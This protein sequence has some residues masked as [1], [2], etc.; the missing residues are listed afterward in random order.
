MC[1]RA[2]RIIEFSLGPMN[3]ECRNKGRH[4]EPWGANLSA[5]EQSVHEDRRMLMKLA[6]LIYRLT[7]WRGVRQ[8]YFEMYARC[9]R[10]KQVVADVD[11][12]TYAL[13][14]GE[15]IDL[16]IF[17]RTFEPGVV[18]ALEK[19]SRLGMVVLDIGANI[20]AHVL[21]LA[22]RVGGTG[23]VYAFEPTTFAFAK[24]ERNLQLNPTLNVVATRLALSDEP[25]TTCRISFR[26]SWRTDGKRQDQSC[27]ADFVKLDDW[28][29][30]HGVAHVDLIKLD[31]DGNEYG[32][33]AGG[34]ELLRRSRPP[35]IMELVGV[36]FADSARNPFELL[37]SIGYEFSNIDT[38]VTYASV[39]EMARLA[40]ADDLLMATSLN[41]LAMPS[42]VSTR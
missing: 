12:I 11:G 41:I 1:S 13:D 36:H 2:I 15:M 33:L 9:V 4:A 25:K 38:G 20:G 26:A 18:A 14:L 35:L 39:A 3:V 32:V 22:K 28:A 40:P 8:F 17:L 30:Q 23:R 37:A 29:A 19:H 31:V 24:L 6:H 34:I 5:V 16:M 7:P 42:R 10:H 27:D 21:R